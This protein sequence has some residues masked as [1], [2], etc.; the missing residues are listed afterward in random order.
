MTPSRFDL[1]F[2]SAGYIRKHHPTYAH[3]AYHLLRQLPV[4]MWQL[5][6]TDAA[7]SNNR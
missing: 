3:T 1:F 4:H 6:S 7:S 2:K 5:A